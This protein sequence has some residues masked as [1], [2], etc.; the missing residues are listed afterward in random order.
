[1]LLVKN[2]RGTEILC[3]AIDLKYTGQVVF[4][5]PLRLGFRVGGYP[6]MMRQP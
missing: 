3:L 5:T 4:S 1:M 6:C 2:R